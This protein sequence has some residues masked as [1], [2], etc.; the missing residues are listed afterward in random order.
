MVILDSEHKEDH[1]YQE[2]MLYCDLVDFNHYL[3]VEDTNIN[4]HPV[5]KGY[6]RGPMEAV[7]RFLLERPGFR[8]DDDLWKRNLFSF[9]QRGWLRR[10]SK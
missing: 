9:H 7:E 2:L 8:R 6:G 10:T 3:V 5:Y 4:G 1:V